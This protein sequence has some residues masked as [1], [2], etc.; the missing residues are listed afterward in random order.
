MSAVYTELKLEVCSF[1]TTV[2][3]S[4]VLQP[5]QLTL[6]LFLRDTIPLSDL[7]LFLA[8]VLAWDY[9]YRSQAQG[10]VLYYGR[11]S[12]WTAVEDI[13]G[14]EKVFWTQTEPP[15]IRD[16]D[17]LCVL[18]G[19][20]LLHHVSPLP[21]DLTLYLPVRPLPHSPQSIAEKVES[22]DTA[23]IITAYREA[24]ERYA[25]LGEQGVA[26]LLE[27]LSTIYNTNLK[28]GVEWFRTALYGQDRADVISPGDVSFKQ[29]LRRFRNYLRNNTF[30]TQ[31][32]KACIRKE[33]EGRV[34]ALQRRLREYEGQIKSLAQIVTERDTTISSILS[35]LEASERVLNDLRSSQVQSPCSE[36]TGFWQD[37]PHTL[38]KAPSFQEIA[39]AKPLWIM[40]KS[41]W[42]KGD[43]SP[44]QGSAMSLLN[45]RPYLEPLPR[46][47]RT[48]VRMAKSGEWKVSKRLS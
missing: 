5:H 45:P 7:Q 1:G 47:V 44:V 2:P 33:R 26:Y 27:S 24:K 41:T 20:K 13:Q 48:P 36:G 29:F 4:L 18:R 25:E 8:A 31:A 28:S 19:C 16:S 23:D 9:H 22:G 21:S 6:C 12:P 3:T 10:L 34:V 43:S 17:G 15:V 14:K 39:A 46:K 30:E 38:H 35:R 40:N 11:E 32:S 42:S 37:A